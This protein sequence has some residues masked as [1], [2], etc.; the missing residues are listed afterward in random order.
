MK[1]VSNEISLESLLEMTAVQLADSS[2][3]Q[4]RQ[5]Q[6]TNVVKDA[7]RESTQET[8]EA[9]RRQ[10]MGTESEN[11]VGLLASAQ[12]VSDAQRASLSSEDLPL[13]PKHSLKLGGSVDSTEDYGGMDVTSDYGDAGDGSASPHVSSVSSRSLEIEQKVSSAT[14]GISGGTNT[15]PKR[16]IDADAITRMTTSSFKPNKA[17][18]LENSDGTENTNTSTPRGTTAES[19]RAKPTALLSSILSNKAAVA[20][21]TASPK[22]SSDSYHFEEVSSVASLRA[23]IGSG[24]A[25]STALP[26]LINSEGGHEIAIV[27]PA[28]GSGA[29]NIVMKGEAVV[30][31]RYVSL[32]Y[33]L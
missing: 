19:P 24:S 7:L 13:S 6:L 12:E 1:L 21:A 29:K 10:V 33:F 4:R 15:K 32:R 18:R 11:S 14:S 31:D 30:G 22:A 5:Q 16:P 23:P 20:A 27:R 8:L 3:Q 26:K 28:H 2:T 9:A 17:P 25:K